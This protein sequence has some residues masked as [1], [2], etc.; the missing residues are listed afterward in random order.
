MDFLIDAAFFFLG[1]GFTQV[2][3]KPIAERFFRATASVLL[4]KLF[5]RLDPI[6]PESIVKMD[7][8]QLEKR[9]YDA[10]QGVSNEEKVSLS[11]AQK[12]A[13]FEEFLTL[14]NPLV[15]CSKIQ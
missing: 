15:A 1:T 9:I 11:E 10:I 4:P 14:Y 6:L 2:V 8:Q 5:D 13:L 3:V 7:S 12:K